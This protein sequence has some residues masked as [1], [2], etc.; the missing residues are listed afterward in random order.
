MFAATAS[1]VGMQ[2][3]VKIGRLGGM[4]TTEV[5]FFRTAPGLPFLWLALRRKGH[6]LASEDWTDVTIRSVLGI[7]AMGTNFAALVWLTLAQ[8]STLSLAQPIFVALAA[9]LVLRE[10]TRPSV[11]A[12]LPLA[13][14]GALAIVVP[15]VSSHSIPPLAAALAVSSALFSAF[16]QMWVRKATVNDPP[17]RVVFHFAAAVSIVSLAL[18]LWL[19]KFRHVPSPSVGILLL[20]IVGMAGFGTLGQALL[21]RAYSIGEA[22]PVSMV[23]YSGV[24]M[25][26][27]LDVVL[28]R[29][30]PTGLS[31]LGAVL[32]VVAGLVLLRGER[33]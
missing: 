14:A 21:T 2:A 16:A 28:W 20:E 11:V 3:V 15:G 24:A 33:T 32:M 8:F 9:P 18:G 4:D 25:S 30:T 6:G 5:M 29:A 12:A 26:F 1:F 19:G 27:V 22:A 17:D 13:F 23:A 7:F 10:R 31:V